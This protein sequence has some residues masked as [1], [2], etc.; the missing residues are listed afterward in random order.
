MSQPAKP[1][2]LASFD[3]LTDKQTV[4]CILG[5][6]TVLYPRKDGVRQSTGTPWSIQNGK[7][8]ADGVELPVV[9]MDRDEIPQSYK[10]REIML[11]ASNAKGLSGLYAHDD[12]YQGTITRKLKVTASA[13]IA[14]IGSSSP[15]AETPRQQQRPTTQ[16]QRPAEEPAPNLQDPPP[17]RER[18]ERPQPTAE[19]R[20]AEAAKKMNEAR[21]TI[22]QTANLHLICRLAVI[23]YEAP[24]YKEVTG[25]TMNEGEVQAATSSIFIKCDKLGLTNSM[26]THPFTADELK[27]K[28]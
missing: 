3:A 21:R 15:A 17:P 27:A 18:R 26:P 20:D 4:G 22:M 1:F 6:L 13:E 14:L 7:L 10:G 9:F 23:N 24:L 19:E 2:P 5:T 11:T 28:K 12:D 25:H 16:Q 8:V